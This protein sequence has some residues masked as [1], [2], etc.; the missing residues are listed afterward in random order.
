MPV[1]NI[2]HTRQASTTNVIAPSSFSPSTAASTFQ[3]FQLEINQPKK[4][5][6]KTFVFNLNER[7]VHFVYLA[8]YA[9][10]RFPTYQ[11]SWPRLKPPVIIIIKRII[12][13]HKKKH[14]KIK[15][16]E[17]NRFRLICLTDSRVQA[18]RQSTQLCVSTNRFLHFA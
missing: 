4:N 12:Y 2:S 10:Q 13:F 16:Y 7:L 1:V 8:T 6:I 15:Q 14:V 18:Y 17:G 5:P 9:S 3:M 11:A